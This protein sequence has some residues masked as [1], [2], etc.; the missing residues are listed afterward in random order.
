MNSNTTIRFLNCLDKLVNYLQAGHTS[1]S[2][3][4]IVVV[5]AI[6]YEIFGLV[7][8]VVESN[9]RSDSD[10]LENGNIGFW[11]YKLVLNRREFLPLD[12]RE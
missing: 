1:I 9:H 2:E 11:T 5:N 7:C 12:H 6:V 3:V 10:F 8:F 4:Q